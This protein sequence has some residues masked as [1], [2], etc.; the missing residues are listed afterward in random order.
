[1]KKGRGKKKKAEGKIKQEKRDTYREND[2][3]KK[4]IK[5]NL[6]VCQIAQRQISLLDKKNIKLLRFLISKMLP[7]QIK[8]LEVCILEI[9]WVFFPLY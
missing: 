2:R 6:N 4:Q 7:E 8:Y 1:M 3:G 5:R 9:I